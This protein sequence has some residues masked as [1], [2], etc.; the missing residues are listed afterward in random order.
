M[1]FFSFGP[2]LHSLQFREN[3]TS[4]R[5]SGLATEIFLEMMGIDSRINVKLKGKI[6]AIMGCDD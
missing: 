1:A 5:G 2:P 3:N 6:T 4:L